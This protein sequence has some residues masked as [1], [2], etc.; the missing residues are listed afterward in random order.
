MTKSPV[1]A[2][3]SQSPRSPKRAS[4]ASA[5]TSAKPQGHWGPVLTFPN[6]AIHSHVLPNGSVLMWG[7]RDRPDQ[8]LDEHEC[9]PFVWD[10]T[11]PTDPTDHNPPWCYVAG[12]GA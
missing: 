7:R 6:A 11:D 4:A 8:S 3:V 2:A 10:P 5:A 9:T 1:K 12:L